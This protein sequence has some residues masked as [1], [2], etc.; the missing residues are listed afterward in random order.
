MLVPVAITEQPTSRTVGEG[1]NATFSVTATGT[2]RAY[3]WCKGG[4]AITGATDALY[5][6][7]NAQF[8]DAA[9]YTVVV[10][11][12]LNSVTSEVATLTVQQFPPAITDQPTNQDAAVG[13]AA[14][15]PL[16]PRAPRWVTSG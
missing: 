16:A 8:G 4:A 11:N 15:S 3:Q 1:S 6:I 7:N 9:D 13:N 14:G 10:S 5:S 2:P 12:I